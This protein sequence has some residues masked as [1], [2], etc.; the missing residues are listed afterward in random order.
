MYM[1]E[2]DPQQVDYHDFVDWASKR[3]EIGGKSGSRTSSGSER[4]ASFGRTIG[5]LR[6]GSY[7]MK[8]EPY[9]KKNRCF[10]RWQV[11]LEAYNKSGKMS[12]AVYHPKITVVTP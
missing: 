1:R 4:L 2:W 3:F 6:E 10:E 9:Q 8:I 7:R 12:K 11:Q 5:G